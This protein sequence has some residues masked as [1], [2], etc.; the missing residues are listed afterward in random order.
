MLSASVY[1]DLTFSILL[2]T[3]SFLFL[4]FSEVFLFFNFLVSDND[5]LHTFNEK[6]AS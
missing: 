6:E 2:Y 4:I 1:I 3:S 5:V